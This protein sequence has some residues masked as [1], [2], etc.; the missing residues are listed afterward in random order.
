MTQ[1]GDRHSPELYEQAL[2]LRGRGLTY[3]NV[4]ERL[5]VS[6]ETV[7]GWCI[8]QHKP[9]STW[10]KEEWAEVNKRAVENFPT[11]KRSLSKQG[12]K[13]PMWKGN[14]ASDNAGRQRAIRRYPTSDGHERH[15]LDGDPLHNESENIKIVT[16]KQHME[17]DGRM[18][19]RDSKGRFKKK[20]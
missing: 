20:E 18:S 13:N 16:R 10:T 11:E 1:R 5:G 14:E 12:E 17:E 9:R 15:H 7:R 2:K 3:K 8:G 19:R 4:S 6:R